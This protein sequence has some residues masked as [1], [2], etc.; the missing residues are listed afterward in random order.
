MFIRENK[1]HRIS[2][3]YDQNNYFK[4]LSFTEKQVFKDINIE[5]FLMYIE[6][7]LIFTSKT[8]LGVNK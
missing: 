3:T 5:A 8:F 6:G 4:H 1:K 7:E 2:N